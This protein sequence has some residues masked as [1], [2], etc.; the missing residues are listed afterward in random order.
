MSTPGQVLDVRFETVRKETIEQLRTLNRVIFPLNY[1]DRVYADILACGPVSQLAF[2]RDGEMVGAIACR[3]ENTSEGP[4]LYILTLGVLA[5]YRRLGVGARLLGN[6]LGIVTRDLPEVVAAVLHVQVGNGAALDLY[7]H[8]GFSVGPVVPGYYPR[9]NPPD[10]VL[11][12][13]QL[14]D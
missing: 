4:V 8:A 3:L 13:K 2:D 9:L 5:P 1:S 6:V 11:L 10:A 14:R 12:R 7:R